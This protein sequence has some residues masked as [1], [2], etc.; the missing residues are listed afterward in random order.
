MLEISMSSTNKSL[1]IDLFLHILGSSFPPMERRRMYSHMWATHLSP[2]ENSWQ[3]FSVLPP[4]V[5]IYDAFCSV[6]FYTI[7]LFVQMLLNKMTKYDEKKPVF[8]FS[9]YVFI[10][11]TLRIQ[12]ALIATRFYQT[13]KGEINYCKQAVIFFRNA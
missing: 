10:Q 1:Q 2:K 3:W 4:L 12:G 6:L 11:P 5:I 8:S 7:V 13:S 9:L